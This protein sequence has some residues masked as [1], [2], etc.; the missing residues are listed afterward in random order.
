M[1]WPLP[2]EIV[3]IINGS[4]VVPAAAA[5]RLPVLN[6]ATEMRIARL[7]EADRAEVDA[8]VRA[9]RTAFDTGPWPRM[10]LDERKAVMLQARRLLLENAAE[11]AWLECSNAGLPMRDIRDR[12]IPRLARNFEYFAELVSTEAGEL[13][14]QTP[15]FVTT[16][17]REPAGVA[18]LLAPWNAP[19]ALASMKIAAAIAAGNTCVLKPSE[20]TALSLPRLVELLHEA[21]LPPGVVNLVNGRG[22]VTGAALAAHPGVDRIAFTGGTETGRRIMAAAAPNLTPVMLELGGKSANIVF[23][24]ADLDRALDGALIGIFSNNGQQCLAGSRILVQR[25]VADAFMERFVERARN[26]RVGDP[27][28]PATEIGPLAYEAHFRRVLGY[29]DIA[30]SEG[31]QLLIGGERLGADGE[32]FYLQPTAVLADPASR[33]AREEIFGPFATFHV[34]DTEDEAVRIANDSPYGLVAYVW[35]RD[36]GTAFRVRDGLRTGTV[37]IN[38]PL[39]REIRAPFG[40]CKDSGLGRSGGREG[41]AFY[42]ETK[43]T[44]IA[45]EPPPLPRLGGGGDETD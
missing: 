26:L 12:H 15:G 42:T 33:V 8:A 35:T 19:L 24:D 40:G 5:T 2:D 31:A 43:V 1:A 17:G 4:A 9:A 30:R 36:I 3:S 11:L 27:M 39:M 41:L 7:V 32:G 18:A 14:E 20:H 37:W 10:P 28:D 29:A 44:T 6:P 45:V 16:V 38:T 22:A 25:S 13:Y 34:F 21:G 23:A